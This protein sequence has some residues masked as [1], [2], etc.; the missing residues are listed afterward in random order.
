MSN[1]STFNITDSNYFNV[2]YRVRK[3]EVLAHSLY[4]LEIAKHAQ[5][6]SRYQTDWALNAI[7]ETAAKVADELQEMVYGNGFIAGLDDLERK[8]NR[9]ILSSAEFFLRVAEAMTER[10]KSR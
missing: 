1:T 8:W 5:A 9:G 10:L 7:N 3:L 2:E 4:S 6:F